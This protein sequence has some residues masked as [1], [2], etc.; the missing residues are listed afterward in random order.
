RAHPAPGALARLHAALLRRLAQ[1]RRH[2][3]RDVLGPALGGSRV[4][5]LPVDLAALAHD[6]CLDLGTAEVDAAA[7]LLGRAHAGD[8]IARALWK[9]RRR[10]R[11][12]RLAPLVG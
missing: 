8:P 7:Q 1:R 10:G 3:R 6:R 9:A 4:P 11:A 2:L 5:G 12:L